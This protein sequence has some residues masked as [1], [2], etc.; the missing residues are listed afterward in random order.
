MLRLCLEEKV[1]V[2]PWSPMARGRLSR[3]W[4]ERTGSGRAQSDKFA[5]KLYQHAEQSDH[6]IVDAV[7][8]VA[9]Q[10]GVSMSQIALAWVRQQ[11][12][13]SSPIIGATKLEQLDDAVASLDV[14]LTPAERELLES[15]YLPHAISIG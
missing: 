6:A 10:R 4:A 12:S 2:L 7:E 5:E 14:T 15:P 8:H 11:P 9:R 3:P 1:G 13:V